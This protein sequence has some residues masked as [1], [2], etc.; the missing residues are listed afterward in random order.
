MNKKTAAVNKKVLEALVNIGALNSLGVEIDEEDKV[1]YKN[2]KIEEN[3][4]YFDREQL[5]IFFKHY[6]L[7]TEKKSIPN[8][9]IPKSNFKGKILNQFEMVEEDG[10]FVIPEDKLSLVE[11][12]LTEEEKAKYKTRKKPKGEFKDLT[13]SVKI[14]PFKKVLMTY[15]NELD[16]IKEDKIANYINEFEALG[17]SF[18]EHPCQKYINKIY[19]KNNPKS[20]FKD[21]KDGSL[22]LTCGFINGIEEKLTKN[23]KTYY[24]V[25]LVTPVDIVQLQLWGNQYEN[26]KDKIQLK[27]LIIVRGIKG[28][29]RISVEAIE[30]VKV[31]SKK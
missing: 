2:T 7:E 29:G 31:G 13:K 27:K 30:P 14:S 17:Y 26:L 3:K 20:T 5:K 11:V 4:I 25:N 24:V 10:G 16:N 1:L 21:I 6:I 19:D 22:C 15:A 12:D 9:L 18:I 23:K 8:Y 28:Y